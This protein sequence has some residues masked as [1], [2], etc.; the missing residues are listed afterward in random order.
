MMQTTPDDQGRPTSLGTYATPSQPNATPASP[1]AVNPNAASPYGAN[2]GQ[3]PQWSIPQQPQQP[4]WMPGLYSPQTRPIRLPTGRTPGPLKVAGILLAVALLLA[5]SLLL[6]SGLGLVHGSPLA[7]QP[8]PV[9]QPQPAQNSPSQNPPAQGQPAQG[10]P[11]QNPP[12]QQSLNGTWV[13]SLQEGVPDLA[14]ETIGLLLNMQ[15][16]G[17]Q[18]TGTS[19]ACVGSPD[20]QPLQLSGSVDG[21]TVQLQ[22]T[23]S[24]TSSSAVM[25]NLVGQYAN[26]AISFADPQGTFSQGELRQGSQS[27]FQSICARLGS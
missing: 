15:Q 11:A 26:G 4:A 21:S 10:Q 13:G 6:G 5:G 23:S 19:E 1:N 2:L 8:A 18:L 27:D 3:S 24:S 16:N 9:A 14:S 12:T 25:I 7:Q 20:I 22:L 17:G